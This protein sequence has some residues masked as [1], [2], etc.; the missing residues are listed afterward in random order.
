MTVAASTE[1]FEPLA[2]IPEEDL[3][4]RAVVDRQRLEMALE[5]P[6][7]ILAEVA[8]LVPATFAPMIDTLAEPVA[9]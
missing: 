2:K 9:G 6:T 3:A 7:R 5:L 4:M 8:R 1:V